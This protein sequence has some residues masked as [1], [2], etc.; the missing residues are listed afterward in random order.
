[1]FKTKLQIEAGKLLS[2]QP[3]YAHVKEGE[4][5]DPRF[6]ATV[7]LGKDKFESPNFCRTL[8]EAQNSAAEVAYRDLTQRTTQDA[9]SHVMH[10]NMLQ[11][12]ATKHGLGFPEY[13]SIKGGSIHRP[14]FKSSV[15]IDGQTYHCEEWFNNVRSAGQAAAAVALAALSK[16]KSLGE[17]VHKDCDNCK[18]LL[19]QKAQKEGL[20]FPKY[21]STISGPVHTPSFMSR[22]YFMGSTYEGAP[23]ES[24]KEA[25]KNAAKVA[26]DAIKD[27]T[28]TP[29]SALISGKAHSQLSQN[30]VSPASVQR[31]LS[32]PSHIKIVR[33]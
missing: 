1:M 32:L 14:Q 22:V 18:N 28:L 25:E 29:A 27:G 23:A 5:H 8:K 19:A 4:D 26:W 3:T 20:Q 16:K 12:F 15:K 13:S 31:N 17:D 30:A 21:E 2:L 7:T 10:K 24:K 9:T 6:K 33:D 11:E